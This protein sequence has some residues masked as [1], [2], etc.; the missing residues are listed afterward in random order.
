[1]LA[2]MVVMFDRDIRFER[3][4]SLRAEFD[5]H[6]NTIDTDGAMPHREMV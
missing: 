3:G 1:M 2:Y 5:N 4:V 6:L